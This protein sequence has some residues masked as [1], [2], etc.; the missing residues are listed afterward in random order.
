M[1]DAH[2]LEADSA[3]TAGGR[4]AAADDERACWETRIGD[5]YSSVCTCAL[6]HGHEGSHESWGGTSWDQE[7]GGLS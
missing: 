3:H 1:S 4:R 7:S 2:Y 6:P 5:G